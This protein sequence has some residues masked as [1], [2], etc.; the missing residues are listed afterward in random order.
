MFTNKLEQLTIKNNGL[1]LRE[2]EVVSYT[3]ETVQVNLVN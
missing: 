1:Q 2:K 3:E